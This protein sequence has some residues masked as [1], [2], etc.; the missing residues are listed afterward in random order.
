M[1]RIEDKPLAWAGWE[2][3]NTFWHFRLG[4]WADAPGRGPVTL[5]LLRGRPVGHISCR[6][7]V[8]M[9]MSESD[10][11]HDVAE[12]LSEESLSAPD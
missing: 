9:R 3:C 10:P 12:P 5:L 4:A 8:A 6:L 2:F 1:P 11:L 7:E